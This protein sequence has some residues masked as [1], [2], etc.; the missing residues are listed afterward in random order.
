[1]YV[2]GLYYEA[3]IENI[4]ASLN[5]LDFVSGST[6][7]AVMTEVG[8]GICETVCDTR[9]PRMYEGATPIR[10]K[11]FAGM[12]RSRNY[13]EASLGLAAINAYYN[14]VLP[15]AFMDGSDQT[16]Y[17]NTMK[18]WRQAIEGKRVVMFGHNEVLD[19]CTEAYRDL[20]V[21]DNPGEVPGAF[22]VAAATFSFADCDIVIADC[23][24]IIKKSLPR[25]IGCTDHLA[26]VGVGVPAA[27]PCGEDSVRSLVFYQ[28]CDAA[29]TMHLIRKGASVRE[30]ADSCKIHFIRQAL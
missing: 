18:E 2:S 19:C 22:P 7:T 9:T 14:N 1:M 27:L 23:K 16:Q 12:M 15:R 17:G 5:V 6:A 30:I 29:T 4:P 26:L 25:L 3:L 10:L 28:V 24:C 11:T 13:T 8:T 20:I 21:F